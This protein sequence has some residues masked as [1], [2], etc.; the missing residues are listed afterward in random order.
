MKAQ[1]VY[2]ALLASFCYV[3]C[4]VFLVFFHVLGRESIGPVSSPLQVH[5]K[6]RVTY[7]AETVTVI[8]CEGDLPDHLKKRY[9]IRSLPAVNRSRV[10]VSLDKTGKAHWIIEDLEPERQVPG[11]RQPVPPGL[12]P[13]VK[14]TV[15]YDHQA[16]F[17]DASG[18]RVRSGR[19]D[20]PD[21][22]QINEFLKSA[23]GR[24]GDLQQRLAL[25][26]Q[27]GSMV[28]EHPDG[29]LT[30]RTRQ[31]L[32][33]SHSG[34]GP[35]PKAA[36]QEVEVRDVV[37]TQRNVI[38]STV[39][40]DPSGAVLEETHLEYRP[41]STELQ[42][43]HHVSTVTDRNHIKIKRVTDTYFEYL[44]VVTS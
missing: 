28:Y 16:D 44:N 34:E 25:A 43:I 24:N 1:L 3:L 35:A 38:V 4:V 20:M 32:S 5:E 17:Y 21:L 37:D 42:H 6:A 23:C 36:L 31:T 39:C 10:Q 13:Q 15:I 2:L 18:R 8:R 26:K 27:S 33:D 12:F 9:V 11:G 30:I 40:Y 29:N 22:V 41:G 19:A 7:E 14:R